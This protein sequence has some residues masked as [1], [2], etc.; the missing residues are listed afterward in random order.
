MDFEKGSL[1]IGCW[2]EAPVK[3]NWTILLSAFLFGRF[4]FVPFFWFAFFVLV[5]IHEAGHVFIIRAY[6]LWVDEI[7][8]HGLGGYCRWAGEVSETKRAL[9]AWGGVF[10][11]IVV[12]I[13]ALITA[14]LFGPAR[15]FFQAQIYHAFIDA[16]IF[17]IVFNLIPIEPLDGAKA[18]KIV[19]PLRDFISSKSKERKYKKQ[20]RIVQRQLDEIMTIKV[21]KG[22]SE[23][24]EK[25]RKNGKG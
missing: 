4:E 18:W 1:M 6:Q 8:I 23:N 14:W 24:A 21:D 16:N 20:D 3:L 17:M 12:L 13:V 19:D 11:Q 15:S 7:V 10:A 22:E 9:I 25:L 2:Q 5:F